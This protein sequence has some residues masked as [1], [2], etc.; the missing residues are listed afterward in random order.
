MIIMDQEQ[1]DQGISNT[2]AAESGAS[3]AQ[4]S[5]DG[6]PD[7]ASEG[8]VSR[9]TALLAK[10]GIKHVNGFL[11]IGLV[12]G[13]C[14]DPEKAGDGESAE[15]NVFLLQQTANP[16]TA[17]RIRYKRSTYKDRVARNAMR[18]MLVRLHIR[19]GED[20]YGPQA[21]L[22]CIG[23]D[24]PSTRDLPEQHVWLAGFGQGPRSVRILSEM[25]KENFSPFKADGTIKEE[26]AS[27]IQPTDDGG[28][29]VE[30]RVRAYV[31]AYRAFAQSMEASGSVVDSRLGAGQNYVALAGVVDS[32][33]YKMPTEHR[34]GYGVVM[35]R[36]SA[37]DRELIPVRI[38]GA[39]AAAYIKSLRVGQIILVEGS[40]RRKVYPVDGNEDQIASAHTYIETT[41]IKPAQFGKDVLTVPDWLGA[42]VERERK[43]RAELR[44]R[45]E[46]ARA[47]AQTES[48][49][50]DGEEE[51]VV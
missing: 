10:A 12:A 5:L 35:L 49:G 17:L 51:E 2:A 23:I 40:A 39:R 18:P 13:W 48:E 45:F 38:R 7:A 50:E 9:P 25:A 1:K 32:R 44:A 28:Y 37:D 30:D 16:E 15:D 24:R 36:Q 19:G 6:K 41:A 33:A 11:N 8:G 21:V 3:N 46:A 14:Y 22:Q 26:F 42:V 29:T 31:D 34:A 27:F 4:P 47:Q 20:Q 43:R